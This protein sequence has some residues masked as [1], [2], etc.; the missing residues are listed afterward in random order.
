MAHGLRDRE[1]QGGDGPI[2]PSTGLVGYGGDTQRAYRLLTQD[3]RLVI[4]RVGWLAGE[5]N[6]TGIGRCR[7]SGSATGDGWSSRPPA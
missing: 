7:A 4:N 2:A 3:S 1:A 5:I 6:Q